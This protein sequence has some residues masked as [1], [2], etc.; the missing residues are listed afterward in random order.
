MSNLLL[1]HCRDAAGISQQAI[2]QRSGIAIKIGNLLNI[3]P[4]YPYQ[5]ALQLE[6]LKTTQEL[7]RFHKQQNNTL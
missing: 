7:L 4:N 1:Q 6:Q 3:K 2:Q 5:Y